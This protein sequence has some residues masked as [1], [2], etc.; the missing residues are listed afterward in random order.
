MDATFSDR[1]EASLERMAVALADGFDMSDVAVIVREAMETV[2]A[3]GEEVSG[4]SKREYAE[5]LAGRLLD[6]FF[7]TCTP[8]LEAA[9]E[10]IDIPFIPEAIERVT[11]DPL[12]KAALPK[13]LRPLLRA[14]LPALFD[15]VASATKG[16]LAVNQE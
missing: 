13:V 4:E 16:E 3:L 15:L 14:M 6:R 8:K 1:V 12:L 7:D 9:I 11:V 2:E 5:L 10:A